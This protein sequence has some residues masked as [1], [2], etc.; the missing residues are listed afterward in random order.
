MSELEAWR[1][2]AKVRHGTLVSFVEFIDG[3]DGEC[4]MTVP[5]LEDGQVVYHV[6]RGDSFGEC[7][8]KLAEEVQCA[9]GQPG[10]GS[11]TGSASGSAMGAT[12]GGRSTECAEQE[13]A[14]EV[15]PASANAATESASEHGGNG[16]ERSACVS[17][18]GRDE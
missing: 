13:G 8:I 9:G 12:G 6:A 4:I 2:L 3:E 1:F 18:G 11:E 7:A 5:V 15:E 17:S 14:T 16:G 10:S